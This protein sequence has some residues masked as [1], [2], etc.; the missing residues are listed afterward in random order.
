[1]VGVS[2]DPTPQSLREAYA[3]P[4]AVSLSVEGSLVLAW[5][6]DAEDAVRLV[7][8]APGDVEQATVA[9]RAPL[10]RVA[11][12]GGPALVRSYRKGGLLRAVRGR[13]FRGRWRPLDELVLHH[14]LAAEGAPVAEALGCVV[15]QQSAGWTGALLVREVLGAVDLEAW[16]Y[17][18]HADADAVAEVLGRAGRAVRTVHDA[19]VEHADLH[20]KNLLLTPE[21][22][23]LVIDLDNAR[24]HGGGLER[25]ARLRN[26]ARFQRAIEKHLRR[27]MPATR[28]KPRAF[29]AGYAAGQAA[30]QGPADVASDGDTWAESTRAQLGDLT[31]RKLWWSLTGATRAP[32]KETRS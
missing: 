22:R 17:A 16:F 3:V 1:M 8:T 21:G 15:Q 32:R 27:G 10:G 7:A 28:W 9:G 18:G 26:L 4:T 20:P 6:P 25:E 31:L 2:H 24:R 12:P 5:E 30:G 13:A 23:V 14:D 19:G 29:F 11:A